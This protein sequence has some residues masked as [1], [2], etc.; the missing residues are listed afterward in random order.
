MFDPFYYNPLA[1]CTDG[2]EKSHAARGCED[3]AT[4]HFHEAKKKIESSLFVQTKLVIRLGRRRESDSYFKI[5]PDVAVKRIIGYVSTNAHAERPVE[6]AAAAAAA[7]GGVES[8]GSHRNSSNL[9]EIEEFD[10][11]DSSR[12]APGRK[13][14]IPLTKLNLHLTE[15]CWRDFSRAV[16]TNPGWDVE[17]I[18]ATPEQQRKYKECRVGQLYFINAIYTV[19]GTSVKQTWANKKNTDSGNDETKRAVENGKKEAAETNGDCKFPAK[20]KT[21]TSAQA[22][23]KKKPGG[24]EEEEEEAKVKAVASASQD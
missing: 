17:R 5:L 4:R 20:K 9:Y 22:D 11:S 6:A 1:D 12:F 13:V 15:P 23:G 8:N 18:E 14:V 3:I 10:W 7:G 24:G 19:P 2:S 21:K 16:R